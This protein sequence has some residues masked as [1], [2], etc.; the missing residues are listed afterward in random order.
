[1]HSFKFLF[2]VT[3]IIKLLLSYWLPLHPDEAYYWVWSH[4]L[5]LSY[6]DHPPMIS[7]LIRLG[8]FLEP[9]GNAVRWPAVIIQHLSLWIWLLIFKQ[10]KISYDRFLIFFLF[11]ALVPFLGI[12]SILLTPDLPLLLFWPLSF[13][14]FIKSLESPSFTNYSLFG[15]FLGFGFL[16]KY[17]IVLFVLASIFYLIQKKQLYLVKWKNILFTLF[18]GLVI[19]SPVLIWNIENNFQSFKFQLGHGL[20]HSEWKWQWPLE[21]V[22]GQA[23]MLSP[24][25]IYYLFK[26][27]NE[28]IAL[29]KNFVFF[30]LTFFF[31]TSFRSSVEMNW[32]IMIYPMFFAAVSIDAP[33][34][35]LKRTLVLWG[36]VSTFLLTT[37]LSGYYVHGKIW[38]PFFFKRI[39]SEVIQYKP[40]YGINYQI[41]SALW[42]QTKQ[43]VYKLK[44]ASRFDFFDTIKENQAPENY[45]YVVKQKYN[46]Y[47]KWVYD[48][49][50]YIQTILKFENN[51]VLEKVTIK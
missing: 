51:Y 12:G 7:W 33:R 11:M 45:F 4:N 5:Q 8:H 30:S 15:L 18:F 35:C 34:P 14:F 41:S 46:E 50:V 27:K 26:S 3:L 48:K 43:P 25:L 16:S 20:S 44:E 38:E 13:L 23:L 24:W 31:L 9:F 22:G 40:L 19:S 21:Y 10:L 6:F 47:P 32:T 37:M 29:F 42:Y 17:H 2:F 39:A 49:N 28:S 36:I 1:M